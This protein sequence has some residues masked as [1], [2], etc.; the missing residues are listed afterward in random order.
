MIARGVRNNSPDFQAGPDDAD[1]LRG[2]PPVRFLGRVD[3]LRIDL[4][5]LGDRE[6]L[7]ETTTP[8]SGRDE[9]RRGDGFEAALVAVNLCLHGVATTGN[10]YI[11][12]A[13]SGCSAV[14]ANLARLPESAQAGEAVCFAGGR[15]RGVFYARSL[16]KLRFTVTIGEL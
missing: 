10:M 6:G 2:E 16:D 8:F 14:G 12:D 11:F 7:G 5:K 9:G 1:V 3:V 13:T 4:R 15:G